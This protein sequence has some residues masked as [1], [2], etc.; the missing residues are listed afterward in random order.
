MSKVLMSACRAVP[1]FPAGCPDRHSCPI[2]WIVVGRIEYGSGRSESPS[3][4]R[5]PF[6]P[7]RL[8]A[9]CCWSTCSAGHHPGRGCP[10][11]QWSLATSLD[12]RW[13]AHLYLVD[14]QRPADR[15]K[16]PF[17]PRCRGYLSKTR[18]LGRLADGRT[19]AFAHKNLST[20]EQTLWVIGIDGSGL[21]RLTE[22]SGIAMDPRLVARRHTA[23]LRN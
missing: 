14:P 19:V 21:R 16:R 1:G 3:C 13:G 10:G 11:S 6:S 22:P 12:D 2:D 15:T 23:G 4:S 7:A 20:L 9:R 5:L 18:I 17:R 8:A